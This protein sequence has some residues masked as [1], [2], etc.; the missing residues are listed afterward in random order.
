[1]LTARRLRELLDYNP[2]TGWF[3]WKIS[4]KPPPVVATVSRATRIGKRA[5][6]FHPHS[7]RRYIRLDKT[8]H[9]E[10]RLVWLWVHG[11]WPHHQIDHINHNQTDNRLSNLREATNG[12]NMMNTKVR[13]DSRHGWRGVDP[14]PHGRF[15][16]RV[17]GKHIAVFDTPDEAHNAW[18]KAAKQTYGEFV[19]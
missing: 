18:R 8:L 4:M 19:R 12:Q 16:A 6:Y 15:R 3:T 7:D 14:L 2:K 10:H 17:R 9:L 5:G 13:C 1:M 11:R